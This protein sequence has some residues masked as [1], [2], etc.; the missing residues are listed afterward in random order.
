MEYPW[1]DVELKRH[2]FCSNVTNEPF[3]IITKATIKLV[4]KFIGNF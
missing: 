4:V 3:S 1:V 2:C